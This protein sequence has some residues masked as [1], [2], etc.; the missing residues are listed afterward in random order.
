MDTNDLTEK[1][2]EALKISEEINHLITVHIGVLCNRF[3]N[4]NEFLE[5]VSKFIK[6]LKHDPEDF[7][8]NWNLADEID[9][10]SLLTGL[11]EL[12]NYVNMILETPLENRGLTIE[13]I[14]FG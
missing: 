13:Q 2:Y 5:T 6:S 8:D 10:A 12:Q 14:D 9:I 1:T 11:S 4:E 7:I 3:S